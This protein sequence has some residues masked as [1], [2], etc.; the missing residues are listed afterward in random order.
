MPSFIGRL[1][2]DSAFHKQKWYQS[3]AFKLTAAPVLLTT[4]GILTIGSR[5]VIVSSQEVYQFRQKEFSRFHTSIDNYLPSVPI[6]AVYLLDIVGI[7]AKNNF[8]NRTILISLASPLSNK[9]THLLKTATKI[10]RPD[11]SDF[12]SLPSAYTMASS[13]GIIRILNNKHW[14]SDVFVGAAVGIATVK[15]LYLA[16]PLIKNAICDCK[17]RISFFPSYRNQ[18]YGLTLLYKL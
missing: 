5:D 12:Q 3:K 10:Q 4:Y 16:Y 1:I 9:I 8:I 18:Q 14:M 7:K 6:A 11:Q 2:E 13:V 17:E 15:M